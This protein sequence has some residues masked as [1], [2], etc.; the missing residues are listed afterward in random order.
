MEQ[1]PEKKKPGRPRKNPLEAQAAQPS[2]EVQPRIT[3]NV[4]AKDQLDRKLDHFQYSG[5]ANA[6]EWE[7]ENLLQVPKTIRER[8]PQLTFRY[9]AIDS[10]TGNLR[11]G[12]DYHGW[13]VFTDRENPEGIKVGGDLVLGAMPNERAESY[14]LYV[15]RQST[16]L[17]KGTQENQIE[18]M[19][20]AAAELGPGA[21][22]A[23]PLGHRFQS[24]D[25]RTAKYPAG[26]R[27]G[28][29]RSRNKKT[30]EV[31]EQF[32]G[33]HPEEI[34][35]MAART[36]EDRQRNRKHFVLGGKSKG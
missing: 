23:S 24:E 30:G 2:P 21:Y 25:G 5:D 14:R 16:D 33:Y 27:I 4:G 26:I 35:R 12:K 10:K 9:R 11:H 3:P 34:E 29:S 8:Y 6:Y 20:R 1:V 19:D 22:S 17:V 18:A 32:R 15:Q 31:R 7:K 28:G 36:Q 13:Q